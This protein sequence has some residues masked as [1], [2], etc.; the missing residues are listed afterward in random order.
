MPPA[1]AF[2]HPVSQSGSGA[3]GT[4]PDHPYSGFGIGIFIH[5]GSGLTRCRTARHSG[6]SKRGTSCKFTIPAFKKRVHP[7]SP[8]RWRWKWTPTYTLH[9]TPI[10]LVLVVVKGYPTQ[11]K[12][13]LQ[14]EE[15]DTP[16]TS[17]SEYRLKASPASAF[18]PVISCLSPASA[19]RHQ[20]SV[21]YRWSQISP[22]LPSYGD[23]QRSYVLS[24]A[25]RI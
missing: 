20:S 10:L 22:A 17:M 3:S 8:Y 11:C 15:S 4:R 9:G 7:L 25:V 23:D 2:W 16:C 13:K 21:R 12:S 18:L 1:S 24:G 5:S 14:V 19:F 6:I